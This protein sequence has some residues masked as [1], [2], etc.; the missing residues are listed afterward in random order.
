MPKAT[1]VWLIENTTLT[2]EQI[3]NFCNLHHLEVQNIADD[4]SSTIKGK[5]PI[6]L[7]QITS[8]ELKECE[9][10]PA[11]SLQFSKDYLNSI[12]QIS[13]AEKKYI[14]IARRNDKPDGILWLI[15]N[16]P[17]IKNSEITKLVGTT[18]ATIK[19][20]RDNTH[21]NYQNLRPRDPVLLGICTQTVLNDLID[22]IEKRTKS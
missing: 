3:A 8:Q 15:K 18:T 13:K 6:I 19:K 11:K 7:G 2:F 14:P 1:A 21:W 4:T 16:Y 9:K 17:D 22:K 12:S 5:N 10:D 20:I